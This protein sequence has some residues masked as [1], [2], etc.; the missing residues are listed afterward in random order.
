MSLGMRSGKEQRDLK[1]GDIVI[2]KEAS[3]EEFIEHV[4]ERQTKTRTGAYPNNS[5]RNKDYSMG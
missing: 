4:K 2:D 1:F 5:K 3:G